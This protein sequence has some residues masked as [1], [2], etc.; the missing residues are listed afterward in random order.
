MPAERCSIE[1]RFAVSPYPKFRRLEQS[2]RCDQRLPFVAWNSASG[3]GIVRRSVDDGDRSRR[4]IMALGFVPARHRGDHF[5]LAIHA[6]TR[7]EAC[8]LKLKGGNEREFEQAV[9]ANLQQS[10][11]LKKTLITQVDDEPVEKITQAHL[12]GFRHR[13]DI[14]IGKDGTAVEI[15]RIDGGGS[16]REALGQAIAYRTCYRYVIPVLID[17]DHDM[18]SRCADRKSPEYLLLRGLADEFNIFT[19]V[20]PLKQ[21]KNV[22]FRPVH[23]L[24]NLRRKHPQ[25]A[26]LI[27]SKA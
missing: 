6:A 22:A 19:I 27:E 10:S 1:T 18:V 3:W 5:D 13:P 15:K 16:V 20:G 24:K 2:A 11:K 25:I 14:T 17:I 21:G 26:E 4:Q 23:S 7:L 12:F 8:N 9:V